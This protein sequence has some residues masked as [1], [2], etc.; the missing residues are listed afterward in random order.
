MKKT[1]P[2]ALLKLNRETLRALSS[3]ELENVAGGSAFFTCTCSAN[4]RCQ[5]S[6]CIC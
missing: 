4:T 3:P 5:V 6:N 2:K 1:Q